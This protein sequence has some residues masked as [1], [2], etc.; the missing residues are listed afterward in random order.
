MLHDW[1]Q[2]SACQDRPQQRAIAYHVLWQAI[3]DQLAVVEDDEAVEIDNTTFMRCSITTIVMPHCEILLI[4]LSASSI[5][6]GLSPALTSSRNRTLESWQGS[7]RVP[8]ACA[9]PR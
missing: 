9:A 7:W 3:G 6:T 2:H 1:L 4:N 5:S 8:G